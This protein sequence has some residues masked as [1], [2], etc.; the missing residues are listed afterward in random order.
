MVAATGQPQGVPE[1]PELF[2]PPGMV[3]NDNWFAQSGDTFHAFYLQRP[4][5][6][7]EAAVGHPNVG[8][9]TSTDL[10]HWVDHGPALVPLRGTW[11]DLSIATGSVARHEGRWWMVFT[12][13]G[14][15]FSGVGLAVSDDLYRWEPVGDGPVVPCGQAFDGVWQGEALQWVFL[16]DPYLYPEPVDGWMY[17]ALNSRVLGAPLVESGCVTLMRSRDLRSWEPAAVLSYPR[18]FERMETP[19]LWQHDGHWYLYFGGAHDAG[20]PGSFTAVAG[21]TG[22]VARGNYVFHADRLDGPYTPRG[23]WRLTLPDPRWWYI[24]KVLPGPGGREVLIATMQEGISPP[25]LVSYAE[26]G[27]LIVTEKLGH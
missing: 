18:W 3:T 21:V 14:S 22:K 13:R 9:A 20:V 19:Q 10:W 7:G 12:G 23:Q 26:D 4:A 6:A 2:R 17:M 25:F 16:A 11:N 15:R 5:G 24:A 8:H 27:S 1:D